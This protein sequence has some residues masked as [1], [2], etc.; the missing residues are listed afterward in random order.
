MADASKI[1]RER[2]KRVFFESFNSKYKQ[3][4]LFH[5]YTYLD[6]K[7]KIDN[8]DLFA[9]KIVTRCILIYTYID[10]A[11]DRIESPI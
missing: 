5:L 11:K 1:S 3:G 8:K 9:T 10:R 6:K 7:K 2:K 4:L